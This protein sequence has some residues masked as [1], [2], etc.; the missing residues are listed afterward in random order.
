MTRYF[1]HPESDCLFTADEHP[2]DGL[3][4]ELSEAGY[5][6]AKAKEQNP[7]AVQNARTDFFTPQVN[8]QLLEMRLVWPHIG[9]KR[10]KNW[11]GED[12][13][14]DKQYYDASFF[15]PKT[16]AN[17][18]QCANYM[19]I[20]GKL[21]ECVAG[22]PGWNGQWPGQV[23]S[24]GPCK[25]PLYDCDLTGFMPPQPGTPLPRTPNPNKEGKFDF[26]E[27]NPWAKG[28]WYFSAKS[29]MPPRVVDA[30]NNEIQKGMNGE[31]LGL[32]GG[33]YVYASLN[34][35]AYGQGTGGVSLYFEGIK[36]TRDGDP[37]GGNGGQQRSAQ[38]MFG[39]PSGAPVGYTPAPALPPGYGAAQVPVAAA[40][41]PQP[42]PAPGYGAAPQPQAYASA[43]MAYQPAPQ[44]QAY[45]PAPGYG[46]APQAPPDYQPP[47]PPPGAPVA[48]VAYPGAAPVA[49]P[50]Y[51]TR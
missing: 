30:G 22:Q 36:K 6:Q 40:Y 18:W 4:E 1:F 20:A 16:A 15:I 14:P 33:D 29:N 21:M 28:H 43:P 7:M 50:A 46:A 27:K 48:P 17:P 31:F 9:Q 19:A 49:P 47:A 12:L 5:Y 51:G 23:S 32:K 24:E 38:D 13:A 34:A 41:A 35:A 26:I 8:G 25:W 2:G 44:P 3:V 37:V 39:A 11:K 42:G 10:T 45:A